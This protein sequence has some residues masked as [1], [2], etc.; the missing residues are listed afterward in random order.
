MIKTILVFSDSHG[1]HD[2]MVRAAAQY[3]DAECVIHLGDGVEDARYLILPPTCGILTVRGNCDTFS[4]EP[5]LIE[6]ELCGKKFMI[7]HG[8]AYGVR[9]DTLR[10]VTEAKRRGCDIALFGHTHEQYAEEVRYDG[11]ILY[12]FNPGSIT[13]PRIGRPGYG[14]IRID[15]EA[16]TLT[17]R[18]V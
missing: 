14:V 12:V 13:R 11:K 9:N 1:Y 15:G 8:D 2:N 4:K 3:P 16:V 6:P 18:T 7:C 10:L 17:H 5:V